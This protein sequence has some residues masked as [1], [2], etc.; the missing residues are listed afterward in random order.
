MFGPKSSRDH[1][2]PASIKSLALQHNNL[3]WLASACLKHLA[4]VAKELDFSHNRIETI[5]SDLFGSD[6]K[7]RVVSSRVVILVLAGNR[8]TDLSFLREQFS[9]LKSLDLSCNRLSTLEWSHFVDL[10]DLLQ[11]N[12][13]SNP[14]VTIESGFFAHKKLNTLL[15]S[16]LKTTLVELT[17]LDF[18][19][20]D[21]SGCAN[22][23]VKLDD[24]FTGLDNYLLRKLVLANTT[25]LDLFTLSSS[26]SIYF[27]DLRR[28]RY[29]D[30][31]KNHPRH[32][33]DAVNFTL[34]GLDYLEYLNLNEMQIKSPLGRLAMRDLVSLNE[35]YLADNEIS[36][37]EIDDFPDWL[38]FLD[39]SRNRL[40]NI[41]EKSLGQVNIL[42]L[43][44]NRIRAF[45]ASSMLVE[46]VRELTLTNNSLLE[47]FL[48]SQV[49]LSRFD[50]LFARLDLS[51]N[52]LA[53]LP[54]LSLLLQD[55]NALTH[56]QVNNNRISQ[57]TSESFH[58]MEALVELTLASNALEL[59]DWLAFA[60][61][62]QLETLD[63][64]E[65]SL[66]V[67]DERT[68][69]NLSVLRYLNLSRNRIERITTRVFSRLETLRTL[70]LSLN[71]LKLIDGDAFAQMTL[72]P[73][74][75]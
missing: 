33:S 25:R 12:M 30:L 24:E 18:V 8:L 53:H 3:K 58:N 37:V 61:L 2:D 47:E 43:N 9:S 49:G 40:T 46:T 4:S 45:R 22:L 27:G 73:R 48:S 44:E 32:A 36:F 20:L 1:S 51:H 29:L 14:I 21:L 6:L 70:D 11:L 57:L 41:D 31:S 28:L 60:D 17:R 39:L 52:S 26:S 59:I 62:D 38:V 35:L 19:E 67:V 69:E 55:F 5:S 34:N 75:H 65:N 74:F 10:V 64:A 13:A 15:L 50:L 68:F 66:A 72:L 54:P 71:R 7:G 42:N 63:L 16:N 56:L 23:K